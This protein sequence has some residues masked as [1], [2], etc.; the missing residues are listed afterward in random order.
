MKPFP[1]A[2]NVGSVVECSPAT[3]AARVR[4][5]D[6]ACINSFLVGG[7]I[8]MI[9]TTFCNGGGGS[10]S[11]LIVMTKG[12]FSKNFGDA[13]YRSPY[14]SHAKRAL[15]HLSYIPCYISCVDLREFVFHG[16][17]NWTK[18]RLD[19]L[20]CLFKP[21]CHITFDSSVGR[22]V[23]CSWKIADIHRSLVQIRLEGFLFLL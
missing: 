13:G 19:S 11:Y 20:D 22:A 14:L 3:R 23:D 18:V 1:T 5:P 21:V 16:H 4:F 17:G 2:S 7:R 8:Y 9:T 15:Y 6:V 12:I 10:L